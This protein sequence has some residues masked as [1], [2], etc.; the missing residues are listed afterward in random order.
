[1][2][3]DFVQVF[4]DAGDGKLLKGEFADRFLTY[5]LIELFDFISGQVGKFFPILLHLDLL[6]AYLGINSYRF[7]PELSENGLFGITGHNSNCSG[8]SMTAPKQSAGSLPGRSPAKI[9]F[10]PVQSLS[11]NHI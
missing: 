1:M 10:R 2:L 4:Q 7:F 6:R 3:P 9:P 8:S 5:G 11:L